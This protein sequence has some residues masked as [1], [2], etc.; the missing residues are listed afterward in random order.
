MAAHHA[1]LDVH[2]R[3]AAKWDATTFI[4]AP[5]SDDFPPVL[6]LAYKN[7]EPARSIFEGLRGRFGLHDPKN[8]LRVAI[9][10]GVSKANPFAYA[11]M[12]GP[13]LDNVTMTTGDMLKFM[14]RIN[15]LSPADHINLECFLEEFRRQGR[16]LLVPAHFPTRESQ[17]EPMM[18]LG[19]G[20]Y[21]LVV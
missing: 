7:R 3:N 18:E 2:K 17:P 11:V 14:S 5:G 6:G 13:N 15:L 19:L 12:V 4:F 1:A 20:K 21:D 9:V 8:D 10:R 16:F